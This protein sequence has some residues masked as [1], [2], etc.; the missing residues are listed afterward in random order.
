MCVAVD[1]N[2]AMRMIQYRMS[3]E[4]VNF[5]SAKGE[6]AVTFIISDQG[7]SGSDPSGEFDGSSATSTIVVP[8][9][10]EPVNDPPV[11]VVPRAADPM[12]F[13]EGEQPQLQAV[14]LSPVPDAIGL[15]VYDVD[16]A[17]CG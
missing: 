14:A 13:D 7:H 1:C 5:N 6:E 12:I 9:E 8:I 2:I 16:T 10:I 11:V 3:A 4:F 17:E 15:D